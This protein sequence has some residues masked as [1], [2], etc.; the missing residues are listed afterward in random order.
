FSLPAGKKIGELWAIVDR[1]EAQSVVEEGNLAGKTLHELWNDHREEIF[2][3]TH[4]KNPASRFPLLCKLLDAVEILSLQV[5][6]PEVQAKRLGG[7]P[8]TECW[9]IL[10]ADPGATIDVGLR[11]GVTREIFEKA[12][13][14]GTVE[15]T[16][17]RTPA[18]AGK[19]IFIP[20]GR[21]H[22]LGKGIMLAEIQQNSD[23]TYRVFDWNRKG[24]DGKPRQLHLAES[25]ASIDFEDYEPS[26]Q[27]EDQSLIADCPYFEI[28]KI[29]LTEPHCATEKN[30]FSLITCLTGRVCCGTKTFTPGQFFFIPANM[31]KSLLIPESP[32]TTFLKA[33]LKAETPL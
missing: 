7:E 11:R 26:L 10:E 3:T 17:H 28:E 25:L 18:H 1:P 31:Q 4:L 9:Y 12:V 5:H 22:A 33:Q 16:L 23:T 15:S 19:S 8:K 27:P 20:S 14:D 2:G 21:L 6:P 29:H 13:R 32:D 24:L 30:N